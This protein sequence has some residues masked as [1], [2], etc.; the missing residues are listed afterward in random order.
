VFT[1]CPDGHEGVVGGHT[2][3]AFA[4]NV[5]Q[6][7]YATGMSNSFTA[8]SP[9]TGEPYQMTCVGRYPAYFSDGSTMISTRCYAGENAEVVIW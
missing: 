6:T 8:F 4:A 7:F 1:I 3:C 5:R 2:T 9:V